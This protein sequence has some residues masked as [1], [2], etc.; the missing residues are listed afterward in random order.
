MD[1]FNSLM[2][3]FAVLMTFDKLTLMLI[4]LS[5]GILVGVLP[6][7]GGPNGVA[8]LLPLTFGMDPTSAIVFLSCIYWGA[9]FGGA[10][11]SILF[12]I[13][14]EAWSVATT[15]DGHPMAQ[16][17]QAA[18]ALTAAFTASFVGSFVAVVLITFLA[19]SI[20]SFALK[21]GPPEFFAVYFLTFCTFVGLGR[22]PKHKVVIAL[23]I[24]LLFAGVGMD[25]VTGELRM[26]FGF[27]ELLKGVDFLVAVIGLFGI[28]EILLTIEEKLSF[29]GKEAR[30]RFSTVWKTWLTLPRYWLTLIR[31]SFIGCWL[32]ITPGGAIAAS[33]MG[34]NLAK[35][36]SKDRDS[37]GKGNIEGV[38]APETAAHAAGTAALLPMLALGIP[39][40][41]TAAVLLGGL[42]VWGLQPGPLLFV[43]QKDFVWGL[44]ASMY[45][46]NLVGLI[47]VLATVPLF[48]AVLR[49]PFTIVAPMIIAFC[50]I[51]AYAV[52]NSLFDIW[53]MLAFGVV[54]YVFKKLGY[55]LAPLTLALVLG[56]RAED[57]F[58]QTMIGSAGNVLALFGNSLV[59]TI[60]TLA[61]VLLFWSPLSNLIGTLSGR[62]R[63]TRTP[64]T[65]D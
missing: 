35:Q 47:L 15:F 8:I 10:I 11:T 33:F 59:A 41:G 20:A 32:G 34:Y 37:F 44:I 22:E 1:A 61:F 25:T 50:A 39:G 2:Q 29:S 36:F 17:G 62:L 48:A 60:M 18:E 9:L 5:I 45:L 27:V 31:S 63:P 40:S 28:S 53:V 30:I 3:G 57:A 65:V 19:P 42:L 58:R 13:P 38:L 16:N 54:G 12:N 23:V 55:P 64:E 51:G 14:G 56:D 46:G 52:E 43:E 26:T 49:V 6:G 4:G 7:L 24:G 21:F